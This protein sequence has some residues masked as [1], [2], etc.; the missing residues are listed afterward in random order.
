M[1]IEDY[2]DY[3]SLEI[4]KM[5]LKDYDLA[6]KIKDGLNV[7]WQKG[8][9]C[10]K[11]LGDSVAEW[12]AACAILASRRFGRPAERNQFTANL[13]QIINSLEK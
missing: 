13:E 3:S 7:L 5:V 9:K 4:A 8:Y 2:A 11:D 10:E 6:I 1:K 12:T